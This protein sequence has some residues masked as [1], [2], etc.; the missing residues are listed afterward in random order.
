MELL[1]GRDLAHVVEH[2]GPQP[3]AQSVGW[4][5]E[6][7]DA[8]GEAH[9]LGIVHRDIKPSNLF[10]ANVD[11]QTVVK[12]LDFG[13]AKRV[14]SQE[15]AI[16]QALAPLGTP[17]YMSPEQVRSAK[18][19]DGRSD[20][21][22][23]GVTLYE[24]LTGH[25]PFG[26]ESSSACIAAIAADPVPDPRTHCPELPAAFVAVLLHALEK[27]AQD[28][29]ASVDELMAALAPFSV[30]DGSSV[31]TAA[32]PVVRRVVEPVETLRGPAESTSDRTIPPAIS[33]APLLP[34]RRFRSLLAMASAAGIGI[35][36]LFLTPRCV[37]AG[38]EDA[39][40][41][42]VTQAAATLPPAPVVAPAAPPVVDAPV[43]A[44]E[45]PEVPVVAPVPTPLAA[46]TVAV[47]PPEQQ[48]SLHVRPR[49]P[50]AKPAPAKPAALAVR[51]DVHGGLSNPGF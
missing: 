39:Q 41:A 8:I 12:V 47:A 35:A 51:P 48:V 40:V 16:T 26:H 36:A 42:P 7:C 46:A 23:L 43:L 6:A 33:M 17:A 2:E 29:Y 14:A 19:V 28:R 32:K 5:L 11:G 18:E 3:L 37:P 24:L 21:W 13:I 44:V 34:T 20:V 15:V 25:T 38:G 31:T 9:R 45:T 10:L 27:N 22:S 49:H 30:A 4:I 1:A 50:D